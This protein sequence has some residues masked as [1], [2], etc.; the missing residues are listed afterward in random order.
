MKFLNR[1]LVPID[2]SED[3]RCALR[4]A[5][6]QAARWGSEL[7]LL[8]VKKPADLPSTRLVIE[9][10]A[11]RRWA[12]WIVHTPP[13]KVRFIL[14]YGEVAEEILKVAGQYEPRKII[15]GR[16]GHGSRPE[17]IVT[18]IGQYFPGLVEAVSAK[19]D[20]V[21]VHAVMRN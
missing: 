20:D 16:G 8:H 10:E 13:A 9:E 7:I 17:S 4:A 21:Y 11:I 3:C 5:D 14:R 12:R 6:E 19:R 15:I 18:T 1:I 2:F